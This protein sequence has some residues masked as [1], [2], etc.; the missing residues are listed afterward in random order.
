MPTSYPVKL[1]KREVIAHDTL[2]F[3]LE[4]P[5]GF[6]YRAGQYG[7]LVLPESA[8]LGDANKHG[9]SFASA[10]FE[11]TLRMATRFRPSPF[12]LAAA[13]VPEGS[14]V[15]LLALWGDFTLHK[16]T[17]IPAVFVIGGIGITPVRSMLTQALHDHTGHDL[18]LIYANRTQADAAYGAELTDLARTH[19]NFHYF[20]IYTDISGRVDANTLR[21]HIPNFATPRFYLAGPE[22]MV[23][24]MRA[25]LIELNVDEDSIRTEEFEGY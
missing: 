17:A 23:R 2:E 5:P 25:L 16:N 3:T 1:L 4:K 24:A 10:P 12:K 19:P 21:A 8:G 14:M 18:T 7:D 11:P 13:K 15:E 22:G 6:T 20:P 9:F